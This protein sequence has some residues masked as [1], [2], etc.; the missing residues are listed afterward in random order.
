M[1]HKKCTPMFDLVPRCQVSRCPPLLYGLALSSLATSK[2]NKPA[3]GIFDESCGN[4]YL[5][6]E[7]T[8]QTSVHS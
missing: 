6:L 4:Q 8:S 3:T 7:Y 2:K 1:P 5:L